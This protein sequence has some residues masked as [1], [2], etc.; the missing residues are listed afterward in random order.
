MLD[1]FSSESDGEILHPHRP[2]ITVEGAENK[3]ITYIFT[4]HIC[5]KEK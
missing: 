5:F 4:I 2:Y 1:T 3:Q